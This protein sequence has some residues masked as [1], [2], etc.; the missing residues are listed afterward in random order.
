MNIV[1]GA[2]LSLSCIILYACASGTTITTI[3]DGA[4][5]LID[6]KLAGSTPY[7][8]WD[9]DESYA[10]KE[11]IL[12]KDGY[13]AIRCTI[14]KNVLYVHRFFAP[15]LL[16]LPWLFGYEEQYTFKLDKDDKAIAMEAKSETEIKTEAEH[17]RAENYYDK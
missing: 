4:N 2:I 17:D 9:R 5:V 16:A 6:G 10:K 13:K 7:Y 11:F 8:H 12:E 14:E 1:R 3:P 15:P